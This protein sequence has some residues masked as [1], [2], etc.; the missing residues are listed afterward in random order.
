MA[1]RSEGGS[2]CLLAEV[3]VLSPFMIVDVRRV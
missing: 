1:L 2:K 3:L